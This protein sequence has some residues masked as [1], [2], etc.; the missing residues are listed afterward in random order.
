MLPQQ[1]CLRWRYHHSNLQ[2]MFSQLLER[3]AF[4][5]VTL[6]CEGRTI[7][8]HKIVLSACSTYFDSILSQYEEKD[9]ILIMKDVKYVDIKCL[10]EFMYK[11]EI[12]VDH[13]HLAT[14]LKTAEELRIKGLAEV[15]WKDEDGPGTDLTTNGLQS[16]LPHV[17]TVMET[18]KGHSD[19]ISKR[20][21][22]RPPIDDYDPTFPA[23]KIVNVT[24]GVSGNDETYSNDA[25]SNSDQDQSAWEDDQPANDTEDNHP[26]LK[27]SLLKVKTEIVDDEMDDHTYSEQGNGKSE[28]SSTSSSVTTKGSSV[29]N[30]VKPSC[31]SNSTGGA[32]AT[33]SAVTAALEKEWP[34][35]V[36]MNDYLNTGRRQ[37]FWEEPFTKRVM[38]A[39]KTKN[40]EMK[41]AA[42]LLGVSYGTLYGRYRDAYGCLKHPYRV[43]DFWTEQGPTDIL[44]KLKRKEITLFR[45]AEQLNVTPQTLSNYLISM[46]VLDNE[47]N[48]SGQANT[49]DNYDD[50]DSDEE[51]DAILPDIP[52]ASNV[53]YKTTTQSAST[54]NSVLANCPDITIIKKEKID[55][56]NMDKH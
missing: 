8:A 23:P 14:L 11:G 16:V 51:P 54:S 12:N 38:D 36:K 24:G 18:P 2:T 29:A 40:L 31:S 17:S 44:L 34:D 3:E 27:E 49:G 21:R 42:E 30:S 33:P 45:A 9:P 55:N 47:A 37:Q 46:S 48:M 10:V 19:T 25:M 56:N 43:R 39:I 26:E 5:D 50:M 4:C 41:I 35:V 28:A 32:M 20:K 15:S 1:Y 6:A 53:T 13:C 52:T 7:R 22:G